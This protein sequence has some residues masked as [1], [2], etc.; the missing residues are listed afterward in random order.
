MATIDPVLLISPDGMLGRCYEALLG[1]RG[2]ALEGVF[3]STNG[4]PKLLATEA[5]PL[6]LSLDRSS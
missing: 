6:Y 4:L 3:A 5:E 2:L 1:R